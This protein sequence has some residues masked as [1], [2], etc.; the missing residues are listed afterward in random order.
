MKRSPFSRRSH[1]ADCRK[2]LRVSNP[3]ICKVGFYLQC[4][5]V[6]ICGA[7]CN[8]S[9]LF[10]MNA[11]RIKADSANPAELCTIGDRNE[12]YNENKKVFKAGQETRKRSPPSSFSS[13]PAK[14]LTRTRRRARGGRW[15]RRLCPHPTGK[16]NKNR[17]RR[18]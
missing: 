16:K 17:E 4:A 5:V 14:R 11:W 6:D 12:I 15:Q 3:E 1:I 18:R 2:S 10:F 8:I 7:F 13:V 9:P